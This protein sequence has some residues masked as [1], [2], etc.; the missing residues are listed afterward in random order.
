VEGRQLAGAIALVLMLFACGTRRPVVPP[1]AAPATDDAYVREFLTTWLVRRDFDAV[2]KFLA[3]DFF[4]SK[5]YGGN[6][7]RDRM[8][9]FPATCQSA[10]A[11]CDSI[12]DCLRSVERGRTGFSLETVTV[13][14]GGRTTDLPELRSRE[15]KKM[16]VVS[17]VLKGCNLLTMLFID[18]NAPDDRRVVTVIYF[19]G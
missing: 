10:P 5:A 12:D 4:I 16:V 17:F 1:P 18:A 3:P 11:R 6:T 8:I 7:E 14:A 2:R 19:A 9:H 13:G 15:G